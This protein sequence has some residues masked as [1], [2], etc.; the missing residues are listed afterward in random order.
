MERRGKS[1]Q[2]AF[3]YFFAK[4][5]GAIGNITFLSWLLQVYGQATE[6]KGKEGSCM[7]FKWEY[8]NYLHATNLFLYLSA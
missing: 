8:K 5:L 6:R 4:A 1:G 2:F 3:W 7:A